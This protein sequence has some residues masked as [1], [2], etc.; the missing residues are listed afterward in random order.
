[1]KNNFFFL[2]FI[3]FFIF[4]GISFGEIFEFESSEIKILEKGNLVKAFGGVKAKSDNG[5]YSESEKS[6]YDKKKNTL[7]LYGNVLIN[8][9][10][11]KIQSKSDEAV[12]YKDEEL[13]K[14]Y[15]NVLINDTINKIQSNSDE[16]EYYR[17]E[18]LMKLYGNVLINDT[19]NK[20]QSNSDKAV[21]Y[22][23]KDLLKLE[24]ESK[25]IIEEIYVLKSKDM[26]FDRSL[27]E[28][29]SDNYSKIRDNKGNTVSANSFNYKINKDLIYGKDITVSDSEYN[30]YNL[31]SGVVKLKDNHLAGKDVDVDFYDLLFDNIDNEPKLSGNTLVSN[32]EKTI[33]YKGVFTN[34]AQN[35]NKCPPWTIYADEVIHEKKKK[36]MK[37]KNA[38]LKIFD[39]PVV[40]TPYFF[41]PDPSVKRQSGFLSPSYRSSDLFGQSFQ[42]PYFKVISDDKDM[43]I[44][45]RIFFDDNILLQTEYREANKNSNFILD[46][47]LNKDD[48]HTKRHVFSNISGENE[49]GTLEFN[50]EHITN[51]DYLKAYKIKS[52]LITSNS[53]LHSYAKYGS[54]NDNF[55]FNISAAIYE[56]LSKSKADR[57]EYIFPS[58]GF[59]KTLE[60]NSLDGNFNFN[61][62]G[63]AKNYDTNINEVFIG[64]D[65]TYDS[66]FHDTKNGLRNN[67]KVLFRNLNT[68]SENNGNYSNETDHK[69]LSTFLYEVNYPLFKVEKKYKNY[70]TPKLNFRYSPNETKNTTGHDVIVGYDGVFG[71]DRIGRND[72]VE[73]GSSITLGLDYDKKKEN[74]ETLL[75]LGIAAS[76]RN[77]ENID[78]PTKSTLGQKTSDFFGKVKFKPSKFF[79]VNYNFNLD[80]NLD[81]LNF[82]NI[83]TNFR[84]NN[85]VTSFD[86]L[87]EDNFYGDTKFISNTTSYVMDDH[88]LTFNIRK[89]L[90]SHT[91]E[92]FNLG[93]NYDND[94]I[95]LYLNFNKE[96]YTSGSIKPTKNLF[97]GVVIKD[98]TEFYDFPIIEQSN[99]FM[100]LFGKNHTD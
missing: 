16:A 24:G 49:K 71:L 39:I 78:L 75:G 63:H 36:I 5:I 44:A 61:S 25:T 3:F 40:Y 97:F 55:D 46:F 8:D 77:K 91:T 96:F 74:N 23:N 29:S 30:I 27:M 64:N 37:Y 58:Y 32:I 86:Y 42:I 70:L 60:L 79:D 92:Y 81:Q 26:T 89:N 19:I 84:T 4:K 52:P 90:Y 85:I 9:T 73:G 14:L 67:Y 28:L 57:F 95:L 56:D 34:C 88:S 18:E 76:I 7:T 59:S 38:W 47:S 10:I 41:H 82:Q 31:K 87:R 93:Y 48:G 66:L 80:N 22:K 11:N 72:L 100:R 69:F 68:D 2:I 45:P 6:V 50:L 15:G 62:R 83:T 51:D 35:E 1:M 54:K 65:L 13:M 99:K 21:Y 12:Y 33:V 98:I 43:T 53:L 17:D 94:C 20:I